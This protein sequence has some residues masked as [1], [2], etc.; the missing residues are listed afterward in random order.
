MTE[1]G[2]HKV[3]RVRST[4]RTEYRIQNRESTESAEYGVKRVRSTE[5]TEKD[6]QTCKAFASR[7][8]LW[9]R[10]TPVGLSGGLNALKAKGLK[11]T[12][13]QSRNQINEH[14][15]G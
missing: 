7:P 14:L 13:R 6:N 3:R 5:N 10:A 2:G 12:E 9:V 8:A 4:E 1:Y 15:Q 11:S